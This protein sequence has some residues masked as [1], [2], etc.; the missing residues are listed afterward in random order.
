MYSFGSKD[1][2]GSA[3][4]AYHILPY[5]NTFQMITLYTSGRQFSYE[6]NGGKYYQKLAVGANILLAKKHMNKKVDNEI[7]LR[8]IYASDM[9]YLL[10]QYD[11]VDQFRQL[12][13]LS[14]CLS[15]DRKAHP[16][17]LDVKLQGSDDFL[18]ASFEGNYR[19]H[20]IYDNTL[21]IR[22]FAGAF[23]YND[24]PSATY[25][26]NSSGYNGYGDYTYDELFLAR[27]ENPS[28]K[29]LLSNQFTANDGALSVYSPFGLTDEWMVA[30]NVASSLP[31]AKDI[32]IQFYANV[33]TF[34]HQMPF[35]DWEQPESL[36]YDGGVK[37]QV[38]R[39]IF[40][41]YMPL[42]MSKDLKE[43]S[44]YATDTWI[45]NVRFTLNLTK[46]NPFDLAKGI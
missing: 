16:Y 43:Y 3:K 46:L 31:V 9:D 27:F 28:S 2:A 30:L 44:D 22:L 17:R 41:I 13:E 26:F 6:N 42:F 7:K 29:H 19:H 4:L 5:S 40:E 24:N 34:G 10:Y 39:G 33:S 20:Y 37:L 15:N 38:I 18:K 1:L 45:Q 35:M 12:Y 8:Y 25:S 32:P 36:L 11:D 14:Y 21:D 23:I